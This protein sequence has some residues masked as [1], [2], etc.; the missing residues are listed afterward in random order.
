MSINVE[1][2]LLVSSI[3]KSSELKSS[4]DFHNVHIHIWQVY[5]VNHPLVCGS[6]SSFSSTALLLLLE[7]KL[8]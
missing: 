8:K 5:N 2:D 4:S 1:S 6:L 3:V 7:V